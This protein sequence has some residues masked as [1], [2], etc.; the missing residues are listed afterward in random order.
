MLSQRVWPVGLQEGRRGEGETCKTALSQRQHNGVLFF[1]FWREG[2][3]ILHVSSHEVNSNT[4][5]HSA[6]QAKEVY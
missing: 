5:P 2:R 3:L 4:N 1:F 6:G